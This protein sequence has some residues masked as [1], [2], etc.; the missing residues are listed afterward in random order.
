[1]YMLLNSASDFMK[2]LFLNTNIGYGGASKMI[3]WV[4]NQCAKIGHDVTFLTYRGEEVYQPLDARVKLMHESLEEENCHKSAFSTI[5]WLHKFIK[6]NQFD[7]GVAF[8]SPSILRMALA[9]KGTILPFG[10]YLKT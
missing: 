2:I 10:V 5:K 7:L 4:A 6:T 3:V 1:M 9:A 8:L